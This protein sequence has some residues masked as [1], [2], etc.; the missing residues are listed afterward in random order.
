MARDGDRRGAFQAY[1]VVVPHPYVVVTRAAARGDL[2]PGGFRLEGVPPGTY[3]LV[4]WHPGLGM[5]TERRGGAV[6]R[7]RA[8]APVEPLA[9]VS[10]VAGGGVEVEFTFDAPS[11]GADLPR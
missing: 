2:R 4:A 5:R 11:P 8:A 10:V 3:D 1:V 6:V 9:S 7:Y